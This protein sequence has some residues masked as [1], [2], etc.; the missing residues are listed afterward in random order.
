MAKTET[1]QLIAVRYE[2]THIKKGENCKP[3]TA[4]IE[5]DS[6]TLKDES[7]AWDVCEALLVEMLGLSPKWHRIL[8]TVTVKPLRY[9]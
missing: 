1:K 9:D 2:V 4:L 6:Q 8:G 3:Q 5:I 7:K